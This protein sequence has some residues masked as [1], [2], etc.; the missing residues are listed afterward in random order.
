MNEDAIE[1]RGT[2]RFTVVRALGAGGMG[3]VYEVIDRER[4]QR[5]AL[6]TLRR[7]DAA[8]LYRLKTEFRAL[9]TIH[10][11]N[12]VR[13]GELVESGGQW[14]FTMELLLG[15]DF[16]QWVRPGDLVP[17]S[18]STV[19]AQRSPRLYQGD[20]LSALSTPGERDPAPVANGSYPEV[21]LGTC[22]H[23][24][25]R[26]ALIGVAHGLCALHDAGLVHRDIKPS[27]LIVTFDRR[28]VLLDF[29]LVRTL[30]ASAA[31]EEGQVMGTPAY[32]AP[33]QMSVAH[34]EAASDWYAVGVMLYQALTGRLP[35]T[36]GT[37]SM[38]A[39]KHKAPPPLP[40][41]EHIPED[42]AT[43]CMALLD[44]EP[45]ARP[46]GREVLAWLGAIEPAAKDVT[47]EVALRGRSVERAVLDDALADV[48]DGRAV[49]VYLT[50]GSG[51]GK[52]ALVEGFV[53]RQRDRAGVLVLRG[54]CYER[55]SVPYKAL[56]RAIDDLAL[57]LK[58]LPREEV[59]ALV[60]EHAAALAQV[61]PVLG[62]VPVI[63]EA[64]AERSR[65]PARIRA[66]ALGCLRELLTRL[67]TTR[68]LIIAIDDLHWGDTD[69]A[70]VLR[71]LL[72]PPAAPPILILG[73][74]R[75]DV[76]AGPIVAALDAGAGDRRTGEGVRITR[77]AIGPLAAAPAR[78]LATHLLGARGDAAALAA[79]IADE[80]GGSPFFI[81]EMARYLRAAPAD[82][83]APSLD[84]VIESR[85]AQ[86]PSGARA[87]LDV[88]ALVGRPIA[89]GLAA[90]A[91]GVELDSALSQLR[92]A[93]LVS[94]HGARD[95]DTVEPYHDRIR[96]AV[97]AGLD[98][99]R[100]RELRAALAH[101]LIDTDW[102]DP[103][104]LGVEFLAAVDVGRAR[105]AAIAAAERAAT[106]LAFDR[107]AALYQLAIGIADLDPAER[108]TLARARADVLSYAGRGEEAARE[109]LAVAAD[110]DGDARLELERLAADNLLRGG[111][112]VEG[113]LHLNRVMTALGVKV[114]GSRGR[115]IRTLV[116]AR[117]RLRLRGLE[118]TPR[119]EAS[120]AARDLERVDGLFAAA[121]TFAMFD[122]LRGAAV[123]TE[124]LLRALPLGEER[125]V[126]RAL[127]TEV[128]YLSVQGP[129]AARRARRL[130]ERVFALAD[131]LGDPYLAY[132]AQMCAGF[133]S[134]FSGS[135]RGAI[136]A[137]TE[138]ERGLATD[139][140]GAWWERNTARFFLCLAQ[141]NAGDFL[142]LRGTLELAV[143]D[144]LRRKD[145]FTRNLFATH[146]TVWRALCDDRTDGVLAGVEASL[147]GWPDDAY[148]Q[149]HHV[150]VVA[151]TMLALY[152]GDGARAAALLD[153]SMPM[154]RALMLKRMPFVMG[155]VHKLR[156]Q[157]AIRMGDRGRAYKAARAM[158]R[159][160][161]P[162]G[163]AFAASMR[164]ALA[165]GAG[166]SATA[167]SALGDAIELFG[168]TGSAH[169]AA[170]CKWRLGE[171]VGGERGERLVADARAWMDG[172]G[173]RAPQA[174]VDFLAP[175]WKS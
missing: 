100:V 68:R 34:T 55:E 116:W 133:T 145:V 170:A 118:F 112:I 80:S 32:M 103:D 48:A 88:V 6:K 172:Q 14:F 30:A 19:V 53:E 126:C 37:I 43:L 150:A 86:L 3:A 23:D 168:E 54:R 124:H 31:S 171:L 159:I 155:E 44:P 162:V 28:V 153:A 123:Q 39:A 12:L 18:L 29:G 139:V 94:S 89:Q 131:R 21:P 56:D 77:L 113:A 175:R 22:D 10:H 105:Q 87:L 151:R 125:R 141:I 7:P 26:H 58:A 36:G 38:L 148:Y 122:N 20:T 65:D 158:D 41:A 98:A 129:A 101:A 72:G 107:A 96:V 78:E 75:A 164:A 146:P 104:Q 11:P 149:A 97:M 154:V 1:F 102:A 136:Q 83:A 51:L 76:D 140:V 52:T 70:E 57:A 17:E 8:L 63:A 144:A 135:F 27:N 99:V 111:Y 121:T 138:A 166:D 114:A 169:D 147:E 95:R 132:G 69:S 15:D 93:N 24:R 108:R 163:R 25:L 142:G 156:G 137:F 128:A 106:A 81:G 130:A 46:D 71:E 62:Q 50:G 157:A 90:R 45:S 66:R 161:I 91:A 115:A 109:Y 120:L 59:T 42:L 84:R 79:G 2:D 64:A 82:A 134:F 85:V 61:F 60:P 174:M 67:A 167:I 152:A 110:A 35:F 143:V 16:L 40:T 165:Q 13:L 5:L 74:V 47:G 92:A 173:V 49:V 160:G 117:A 9:S 73:T 119:P 127:A 4:D 33:E